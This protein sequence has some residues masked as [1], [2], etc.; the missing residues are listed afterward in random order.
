MTSVCARRYTRA[1]AGA[2]PL[3]GSAARLEGR[4]AYVAHVQNGHT[5]MELWL[6]AE[7]LH[8]TREDRVGP[9]RQGVQHRT[10]LQ[11]NARGTHRSALALL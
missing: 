9:V 10:D 6:P 1:N 2:W 11:A 3:T 4:V 8:A 5:L 7:L